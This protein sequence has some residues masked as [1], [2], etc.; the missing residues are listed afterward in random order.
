MCYY[1][2]FGKERKTE[3]KEIVSQIQPCQ[4]MGLSSGI[5]A[6]YIYI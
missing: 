6:I 5:F 1:R 2:K 4:P 3:A